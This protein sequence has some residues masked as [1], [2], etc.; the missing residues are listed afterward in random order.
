MVVST[1]WFGL[2]GTGCT[3]RAQL[4]SEEEIRAIINEPLEKLGCADTEIDWTGSP[5]EKL[6]NL[7]IQGIQVS[8]DGVGI[9]VFGDG[10]G[11]LSEWF[12]CEADCCSQTWMSEILGVN[13][14]L[15]SKIV[16]ITEPDLSK[17][18]VDDGRGRQGY[19]S[20]YGAC[21]HTENGGCLTIIWRNSSNGYYGGWLSPGVKPWNSEPSF[22]VKKDWVN[23]KI[24]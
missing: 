22:E 10:R 8:D 5:F 15:R 1:G 12:K 18:N 4:L 13:T 11:V 7:K 6:R 14:A 9:V 16:K 2:S 19:D 24:V 17:Y 3:E 20:V 23:T 21:L